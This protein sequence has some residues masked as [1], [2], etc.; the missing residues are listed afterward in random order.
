MSSQKLLGLCFAVCIVAGMRAETIAAGTVI[1]VRTVTQIDARDTV[2]GRV[3]P[4]VVD[5]DVYGPED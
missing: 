2:N 3:Y 4:G 5:R 1:D